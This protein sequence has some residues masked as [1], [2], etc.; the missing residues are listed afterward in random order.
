MTRHLLLVSLSVDLANTRPAGESTEAVAP[1]NAIHAGIG[2][3]D[4]MITS[5]I[6]SGRHVSRVGSSVRR[7]P[8]RIRQIVWITQ[9]VAIRSAAMFGCPHEA[10]F[11]NQAPNKES[12]LIHPTQEL[13]GSVLSVQELLHGLETFLRRLAAFAYLIH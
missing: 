13:P 7:Q 9:V 8:T 6:V 3:G 2:D 5:Q 12:H 11:A 4:G 10:L 1:E